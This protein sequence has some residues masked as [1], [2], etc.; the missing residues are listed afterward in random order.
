MEKQFVL[1]RS[2]GS[3]VR[4]IAKKLNKSTHTINNWNKKFAKEIIGIRNSE[5]C[6]L[7]K[8]I[9]ESKTQRLNFLKS[10]FTRVSNLLKKQKIDVD[11]TFGSYNKFLE[12]YVKLSNLISS[13]ESDILTVGVKFKDNVESE[14]SLSELEKDNNVNS[15]VTESNKLQQDEKLEKKEVID[16]LGLK[17]NPPWRA[18]NCN[19]TTS[20]KY[21][22]YKKHINTS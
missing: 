19:T 13:Y 10:E 1:M 5:F 7:Q 6:D 16:N 15:I 2:S 12:L 8:N 20:K 9:I 17:S 14:I 22:I 18:T 21:E 11:E 3:S 4:D